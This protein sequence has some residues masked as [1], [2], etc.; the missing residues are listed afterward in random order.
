MARCSTCDAPVIWAKFGATG[1][2]VPLDVAPRADGNLTTTGADRDGTPLV[3]MAGE[4]TPI[5][6]RYTTHFAT[7]PDAAKHRRS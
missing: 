7:C 6:E 2:R 5:T 3:V 1:K 4:A